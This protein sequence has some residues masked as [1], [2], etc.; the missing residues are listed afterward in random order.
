MSEDKLIR[1]EEYKTKFKESWN[2][3]VR[4]SKNGYFMF[5]R[6]FMEYHSDRFVD[7]SLMFFDDDD[8]IALMPANIKDDVLYSHQGLSFGGIVSDSKMKTAKMLE[9]FLELKNYCKAQGIKK[10]IYKAIPYIYHQ[11]PADEDLY[12]LFVNN[13]VLIRRDV[14]STINLA[15]KVKFN[16][17]RKRNIKKAIK[18]NLIFKETN[19]FETYM[20]LL[21]EVL[22]SQHNAKPVHTT[23]EIKM[24]A[25]KFPNNIK[26]CASFLDTKMLAGVIVFEAPTVAHSQYIANG[27]EGRNLGALDFVFDKLINE[28]YKDKKYFDFG[29]STENGGEYLN[30]G[31]V[32]Q[33]Q[34]FGGRT[35]VF[36]FYEIEI[37]NERFK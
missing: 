12:A 2:E 13:A 17:R 18:S 33:K 36:D 30:L 21:T 6:E 1:I 16:E 25:D 34:E 9:I 26:L 27:E 22:N 23:N 4:S 3:F 24:L 19:D 32:G 35:V 29:I 20:N 10:I 31:L 28:I 15:N 37:N 14:S 8:L 5:E 7:N 11:I